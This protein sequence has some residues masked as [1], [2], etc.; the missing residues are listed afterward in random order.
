MS[1]PPDK[2]LIAT[3][4]PF[5]A[6]QSFQRAFPQNLSRV[7]TLFWSTSNHTPFG[8]G[9][10]YGRVLLYGMGDLYGIVILYDMDVLYGME[11]LYGIGVMYGMGILY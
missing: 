7:N 9:V 11:V 4:N 6:G 1:K 10:L 2:P 3:L 5:S 8:M